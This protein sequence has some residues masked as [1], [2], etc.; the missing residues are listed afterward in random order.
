MSENTLKII[1]KILE[2]VKSRY[3]ENGYDDNETL[4]ESLEHSKIFLLGI[5]TNFKVED[6]HTEKTIKFM[7]SFFEHFQM[8]SK[9]SEEIKNVH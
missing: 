5:I 4:Q 7:C 2:D 3:L 1:D 9:L 6:N 8:L